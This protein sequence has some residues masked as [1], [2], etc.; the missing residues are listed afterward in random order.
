MD[1]DQVIQRINTVLIDEFEVEEDQITPEADIFKTLDI[2]SL[3]VVDLVVDIERNFGI[4]L[5][6]EEMAGVNT[7]GKLYDYVYGKIQ[8]QQS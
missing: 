8:D 2:D 7:I 5:K 3:D 1:R 6:T 4:K